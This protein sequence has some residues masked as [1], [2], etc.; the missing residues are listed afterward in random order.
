VKDF[1][2]LL[3]KQKSKALE[4]QEIAFK[5][6]KKI[7]PHAMS[8]SVSFAIEGII[9]KMLDNE[10]SKGDGVGFFEKINRMPPGTMERLFPDIK[11]K[12]DKE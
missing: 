1:R 10:F 4:H 9:K 5:L 6:M 12:S 2:V 7:E 3:N 8:Q 11:K